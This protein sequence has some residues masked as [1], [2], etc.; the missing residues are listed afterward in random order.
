MQD[1]SQSNVLIYT[2]LSFM[3]YAMSPSIGTN[4]EIETIKLQ[5]SAGYYTF[6]ISGEAEFLLRMVL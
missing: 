2:K 5:M 1:T 3:V 6:T 4:N